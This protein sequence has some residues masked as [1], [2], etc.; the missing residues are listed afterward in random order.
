MPTPLP[1]SPDVDVFTTPP[2]TPMTESVLRPSLSR[3]ASRPSSLQISQTAPDFKPDILLDT[4]SPRILTS[5]KSSPHSA[6]PQSVSTGN[7]HILADSH[8]SQQLNDSAHNS[9]AKIP[10]TTGHSITNRTLEPS[11][12][13]IADLLPRSHTYSQTPT[14]SPCFVHSHLDK[15]ASFSEWLNKT[16]DGF[17]RISIAPALQPIS[18][19]KSPS[20]RYRKLDNGQVIL[21]PYEDEEHE[22]VFDASDYEDDDGNG[23]L[24]KKLAETAI[25][26]RE[27]SKQ[28][29]VFPAVTLPLPS[30]S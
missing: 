22:H 9:H 30:Q 21:I 24:T 13:S 17:P 19:H 28:L 10:T 3:T 23:S 7:G 1:H 20:R 14:G 12:D 18:A 8:S 29:G 5:P 4:Q 27:M 11:S 26:V 25:G 15:G 6:S 16:S 2:T